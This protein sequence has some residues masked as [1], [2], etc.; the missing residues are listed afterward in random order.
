MQIHL[1]YAIFSTKVENDNFTK[2]NHD[3]GRQTKY[4]RFIR[5]DAAR[6]QVPREYFGN[7]PPSMMANSK[8]KS[9]NSVKII[10]GNIEVSLETGS[11]TYPTKPI[12]FLGLKKAVE[13]RLQKA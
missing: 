9:D 13:Q 1:V 2:Y 5:G 4:R 8:E 6:E 11:F 3:H 12:D 7:H 10:P